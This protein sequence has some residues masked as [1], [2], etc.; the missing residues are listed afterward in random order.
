[1]T[2]P[3]T[4]NPIWPNAQLP[5]DQSSIGHD[6]AHGTPA[7]REVWS[8]AATADGNPSGPGREA[9]AS[10]S[11][12]SALRTETRARRA[13]AERPVLKSFGDLLRA[14]YGGTFR[15]V[16]PTKADI[17]ALC[18]ESKLEPA[19][20][21]R[22]LDL[23]ASDRTLERTFELMLLSMER[24]DAAALVGQ[25]REF[26]REVLRRHP[27]FHAE[28]LAAVLADRPDGPGEEG[29][30]RTLTSQSYATLPWPEG[31]GVLAKKEAEH[32]RVNALCC[33]LL[34]FRETRGITLERIQ[35]YMERSVWE[36]A[37]RRYKTDPQKLRVLMSS[38]DRAGI[39]VACS[40]L[41]K[42]VREQSQQAAAARKAEERADM[43]AKEL[44]SRLAEV[45]AQL[46]AAKVQVE[47]LTDEN[48]SLRSSQETERAH[49]RNDY[50]DL[51]GRVLRRLREDTALLEEGLHA[52]RREPPKVH[53]MED[54]AERAIDA[55]KREMGRIRGD[56]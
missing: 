47:R 25:V 53:V 52:L 4:R 13:D 16:N 42:Q 12:P 39:A 37:G 18:S 23:S 50:E 1:M 11:D 36:P 14:A 31:L 19:E 3:D 28:A 32:C 8:P 27:A 45:E 24:F 51:R 26:V 21:E 41:E 15:R 43:R 34:W 35:R 56:G 30:V 10:S 54:H 6:P 55:L 46:N 40:V 29:A 33:L 5:G 9:T 20:R 22:L 7:P 49:M 44:D 17:A 2:M 48:G 38:R